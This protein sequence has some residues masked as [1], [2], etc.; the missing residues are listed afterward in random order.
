MASGFSAV[1]F[2]IVSFETDTVALQMRG[3]LPAPGLLAYSDRTL[4]GSARA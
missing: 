1:I 2:E 3:D 4:I